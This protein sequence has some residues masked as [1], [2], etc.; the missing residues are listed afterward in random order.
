MLVLPPN[1]SDW[2]TALEL[3]LMSSS[4]KKLKYSFN[5]TWHLKNAA[6]MYKALQKICA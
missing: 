4:C 3:T 2:P 1:S 5:L 6:F